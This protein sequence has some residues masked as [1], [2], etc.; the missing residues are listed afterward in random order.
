MLLRSC[1]MPKRWFAD[2]DCWLFWCHAQMTKLRPINDGKM[3]MPTQMA[4][5][6]CLCCCDVKTDAELLMRCQVSW[7]NWQH[8][9]CRGALT[10][11]SQEDDSL[12][13]SEPRWP[14]WCHWMTDLAR[15]IQP[16]RMMRCF[17]DAWCSPAPCFDD[18]GEK[19]VAILNLAPMMKAAAWCATRHCCCDGDAI[20]DG[21]DGGLKRVW[22]LMDACC[23]LGNISDDDVARLLLRIVDVRWHHDEEGCDL[24]LLRDVPWWCWLHH[25]CLLGPVDH[26][27][28]AEVLRFWCQVNPIGV[29]DGCKRIV[30]VFGD[31]VL[32]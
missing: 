11:S 30:D 28:E 16:H 23:L 29:E 13:S 6:W 25:W 9:R 19:A 5:C 8:W 31:G 17:I 22:M 26:L 4:R 20:V 18:W 12:Q 10:P 32:M 7:A 27:D 21:A 2:D 14:C 1:K 24:P 3:L 15:C